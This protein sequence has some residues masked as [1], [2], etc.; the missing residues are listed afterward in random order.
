MKY[1]NI[2]YPYP[3]LSNIDDSISG[4]VDIFQLDIWENGD[5]YIIDIE[6]E[7]KNT[8]IEK[9][10]SNGQA[11]YVVE[12]LCS[13][14]LYRKTFKSPITKFSLEIPKSNLKGNVTGKIRVL[15]KEKIYDYKNSAAH[16]DYEGFVINIEEG[17]VLAIFNDFKFYAHINYKNLKAVASFME[18]VGDEET[19]TFFVE[20]E[21]EKINVHLPQ[22]DY[23]IFIKDKILKEKEFVPLIHSSIVLNALLIALYSFDEHTD[24]SWAQAI[25]Y[26][27]KNEDELKGFISDDD[28]L[29]KDNIPE[30]AQILL[31]KPI[32]RLINKLN[33]FD[34]DEDEY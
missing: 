1:N 34:S 18:V 12:L 32:T 28:E 3:V 2:K 25:I 24:K 20:L 10:I 8:D 5:D 26:R 15:S 27:M 21:N 30:I 7:L 9:L 22:N 14:T 17:D 23:D 6:L 11:E 31:G 16:P 33:D 4:K 13:D 29:E 19:D